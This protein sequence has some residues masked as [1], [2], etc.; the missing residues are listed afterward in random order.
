MP[1]YKEHESFV[2]SDPYRVWQLIYLGPECLGSV[3]L[4]F[5]NTIGFNLKRTQVD[6]IA[7]S[8]NLINSSYELCAP[9]HSYVA[10]YFSV[11][12]PH[13][14]HELYDNLRRSA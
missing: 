6:V 11:N 9:V 10:N 1:S 3:Y 4:K 8:L 12:V 13:G 2:N 5:D 14:N 7:Q